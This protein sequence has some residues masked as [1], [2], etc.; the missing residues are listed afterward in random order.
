MSQ[1]SEVRSQASLAPAA[2]ILIPN[3]KPVRDHNGSLSDKNGGVSSSS[4]MTPPPSS[5]TRAPLR[6]RSRSGSNVVIPASPPKESLEKSLYAAYGAAEN[7]PTIEDIDAADDAQVRKIAKDLLA[8]AQEARMSALHFKLQN[9]LLSFTS[10]EAIKRAEVEQ[11]LARREVE[12]LQSS[13]YQNRRA[14]SYSRTP[15]ICPTPDSEASLKRVAELERTNARLEERL[16]NAKILIQEKIDEG[17]SKNESLLEENRLL[18]KR[19]RDNREHL[20]MF[21]DAGSLSPNS[22]PEFSTPQRKSQ[23]RVFDSARTH[24]SSRGSSH[25]AF[26]TL[27]AADRVLHGDSTNV[28]PTRNR[29]RNGH[30]GGAH[31]RGAHS[32][33]S[34]PVTPQRHTHVHGFQYTTPVSRTHTTVRKD[35]SDPENNRHDR[36]STISV[37]DAEEVITDEDIPA[38]Q[39]SSRAT[40]MLR[41]LPEINQE[42]NS[43]QGPSANRSNIGKSSTLLQTK[44]FGQV[45]KAGVDRSGPA[46]Q[47]RKGSFVEEGP[48]LK[49]PK[50]VGL[51][52]SS[53]K[54]SPA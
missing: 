53:W 13:E 39:A 36:D 32:M 1:D 19:I 12:I 48:V 9:S 45:K 7:L 52:I 54:I 25:D 6:R 31:V 3:L 41:R 26:A 10:N 21:L 20:T 23:P 49:K 8:I 27:L 46:S 4:E 33:S 22:R 40:D 50:E 42:T 29:H 28:S 17:N 14:N 5:Q 34:L 24:A 43:P 37:S 11:Q 18:K 47:K 30:L 16:S 44:I 15:Q 51:G 2:E 38:S 35:T